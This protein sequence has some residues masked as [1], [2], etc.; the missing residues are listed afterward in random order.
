MGDSIQLTYS[1]VGRSFQAPT[2]NHVQMTMP[3]SVKLELEKQPAPV[4]EFNPTFSPTF[5]PN[6]NVKVPEIPKVDVAVHPTPIQNNI[7]LPETP[8]PDIAITNVIKVWPLAVILFANNFI[9]A[10]VA[11]AIVTKL[12][13]D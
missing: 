11:Y 12:M 10:I 5:L 7:S 3:D 9:F 2:Q 4:I 8:S 1:A 13:G 6:I